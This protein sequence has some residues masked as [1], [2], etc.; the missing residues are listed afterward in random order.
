[1]LREEGS[2][3]AAQRTLGTHR[4]AT[5]EGRAAMEQWTSVLDGLAA[6]EAWMG[7]QLYGRARVGQE[8]VAQVRA[9]R[10]AGKLLQPIEE[11]ERAFLVQAGAAPERVLWNTLS[12]VS[13]WHAVGQLAAQQPA[14]KDALAGHRTGIAFYLFLGGDLEAALG[15][16]GSQ[17]SQDATLLH[18]LVAKARQEDGN[19]AGPEAELVLRHGAALKLLGQG[20]VDEAIQ[21]LEALSAEFGHR[22]FWPRYQGVVADQLAGARNQSQDQ[23]RLTALA[24]RLPAGAEVTSLGRDGVQIVLV[25]AKLTGKQPDGF[26]VR[27]DSL[28]SEGGNM[29]PF[30]FATNVSVERGVMAEIQWTL[31]DRERA[32]P[33]LVVTVHGHSLILAGPGDGTPVAVWCAGTPAT[34]EACLK[35]LEQ[36]LAAETTAPLPR[37]LPGASYRLTVRLDVRP[38]RRLLATAE[39]DGIVLD[40]REFA[41]L[42]KPV[43]V[44]AQQFQLR[45]CGVVQVKR[46]EL[47]GSLEEK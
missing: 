17:D 3:A 29:E 25:P 14:I 45:A 4:P 15:L 36:S 32:A 28:V 10:V 40:S 18:Q 39:L 21:A 31:P 26:S 9:R 11:P 5:P 35:P 13:V 42:P 2:V 34:A 44:T 46:I 16:L 19:P 1:V 38:G 6:A 8:V 27:G 20:R 47:T 23:R 12:R 22:S 24:E 41:A 37:L 7:E 33:L 30:G 43:P